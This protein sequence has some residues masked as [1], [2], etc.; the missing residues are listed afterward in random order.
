MFQQLIPIARNAFVESLRQP[1]FLLLILLAGILQV[2]NTWNTGYSM[3]Y[4][5][6]GEVSGDN[7]LLLDIGM[8]TVF[9]AAMLL[10]AFIA[11]SVLSREIENKTVLTV[12]SKP[13]ARPLLIIGKYLGVAGAITVAT[14]TMLIYLLFAIRH[15]VMSTAA[16]E[17]DGPVLL[18][19]FGATIISLGLAAWT[20]YFYGW[21]FPQTAVSLLLPFCA[22]G[23]FL[24]LCLSKEWQPQSPFLDFKPQITLACFCLM[25]AVLVLTSIA[26]AASARLK[27]VPTI[28]ICIIVFV[29]S[30]LTNHL[31]GRYA[32]NNKFVAIIREAAPVE[33]NQTGLI[34][35]GDAYTVE[36]QQDPTTSIKPGDPFYYGPS[37]NGSAILVRGFDR[38]Q[39]DP[40][41]GSR[42]INPET[43]FALVVTESKGTHLSVRVA[44]SGAEGMIVR[45]PAEGDFVFTEPTRLTWAAL[46]PWAILPN[47][48][49]FWL[50][51]AVTQNQYVPPYHAVLVVVYAGAQICVFLCLAVMLFQ[52]RDVG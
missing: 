30:L 29:L 19:S 20:N 39:G 21:N 34:K 38:F 27:Q 5:E 23:Y 44:G 2:F 33:F 26:T 9:V 18:F 14:V 22:V 45:P 37:P 16:D 36:L 49:N 3:G 12:V 48:Q 46:V 47:L 35:P 40:A 42:F 8:S 13:V 6:A 28:A 31:L 51:D 1:I 7:K 50:I 17:L 24:T 52:K 41:D 25:M 11:T 4:T 32:F 15:G 43:P 10:A